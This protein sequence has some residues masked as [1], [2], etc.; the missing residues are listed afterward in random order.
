VGPF[1]Y[2]SPRGSS[3]SSVGCGSG[4]LL[5]IFHNLVSPGGSVVGIEHVKQLSEMSERNLA[6]DGKALDS[7][8]VVTGDGR[9]GYAEG[10]RA[11]AF[12]AP[13]V[14]DP[15]R[16]PTKRYTVGLPIMPSLSQLS[17]R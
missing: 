3:S 6:K 15:L 17:L 14:A 12:S 7:L 5:G 16:K 9:Q 10:G 1:T 2:V 11:P 4:Y 13:S 8:K